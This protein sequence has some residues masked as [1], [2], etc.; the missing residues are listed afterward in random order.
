LAKAGNE[1]YC[2]AILCRIWKQDTSFAQAFSFHWGDF[3]RFIRMQIVG[4]LDTDRRLR[5]AMTGNKTRIRERHAAACLTGITSLVR[6]QWLEFSS[7]RILES[8]PF[9]TDLVPKKLATH[10]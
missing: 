9:Q 3:T 8:F 4:G 6:L 1:Q 2:A 10:H 7:A 5:S